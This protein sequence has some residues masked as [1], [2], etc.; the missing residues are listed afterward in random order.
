MSIRQTAVLE[1]IVS[2]GRIAVTGLAQLTD[3]SAVTIRKDL[4][5]LESRGLIRRERG[6]AVLVSADDP[7][8]RLAY[9]YADKVR[10]ARAAAGSVRD[11]ET[12]M[13]EAGSCCTLLAE[14]IAAQH[15]GTT[16]ITNSAFIAERLRAFPSTRVILLGGEQ[17]ADSRVMVGPMVELCAGQF[18]VDQLFIGTDGFVSAHGFT[19]RDYM[20]ATAVRALAERAERVVVITESE[21]LG[22]HGP[23]PLLEA[24]AVST[25]WTD[26]AGDLT[27]LTALTDAGVRV[28]AVSADGSVTTHPTDAVGDAAATGAARQ[29]APASHTGTGVREEE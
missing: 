29:P 26:S 20:R 18:L 23:V 8:G 16:I 14:Q 2:A 28:A 17:Q 11:G 5:E 21:K 6:Y 4:D 15:S 7:A 1:A 9:H 10:I 24:S 13:V 19:G 12:V 3:V 22:A 27:H 25:V